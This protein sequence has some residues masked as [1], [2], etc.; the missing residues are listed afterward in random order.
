MNTRYPKLFLK[1]GRERSLLKGHP[2]LFSGAVAN[3]EGLPE[4]GDLVQ[5]VSAEGKPL[6]VGFYHPQNSIAFR[7]LTRDPKT[8][9]DAGF[10][11]QRISAARLLRDKV[12]TGQTDACRVINAEGDGLPGLVVDRYGRYLVVSLA[13]AG[14]ERFQKEILAGLKKEFQPTAIY[15]RSEGRARNMD[16]LADRVGPVVGR[17]PPPLVEI[18]ENGLF[19]DVD[20]ISGQKTGFFLDQRVNRELV[21]N[22]SRGARVLNCFSYSGGFSIYAGCGRAAEVTSVDV[23]SAATRLAETNWRKNDLPTDVHRVVAADVFDYLRQV[24]GEYDLVILDPPA[25]ARNAKDVAAAASGYQEI[26]R[27]GIR[28]LK[29][30][31]LLF[32]FSC[33]N[34]IDETLFEKIVLSASRDA[35]R[36]ARLLKTLGPGPDHP[37][38]LGHPEGR[39]LKGLMLSFGD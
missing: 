14:M 23:S 29:A 27:Q 25:F 16:G 18:R 38:A 28:K 21:G 10:I 19:F 20:I 6:A 5:A 37:V 24:E 13:T 34:F 17:M 3:C 26:N 33:S 22:L 32:T 1:P 15:E 2:W 12:V 4:P 36:E 39:Y 35:G 30:G 9:V 8:I 31:G 7:L 11:R